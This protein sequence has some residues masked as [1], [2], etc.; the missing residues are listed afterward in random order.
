MQHCCTLQTLTVMAEVD[1]PAPDPSTETEVDEEVTE[2]NGEVTTAVT[3]LASCIVPCKESESVSAVEENPAISLSELEQVLPVLPPKLSQVPP[4]PPLSRSK[5]TCSQS[6]SATPPRPPAMQPKLVH[7]AQSSVAPGLPPVPPRRALHTMATIHSNPSTLSS[8]Q[9]PAATPSM[10]V[11]HPHPSVF[12]RTS[13]DAGAL[14]GTFNYV[15]FTEDAVPPPTQLVAKSRKLPKYPP[16]V[17]VFGGR[18]ADIGKKLADCGLGTPSYSSSD[19]YETNPAGSYVRLAVS[20]PHP[21]DDLLTLH[22]YC[23]PSI[24]AVVP[25]PTASACRIEPQ[26]SPPPLPM[27][28][29]RVGWWDCRW[30][31]PRG[32]S[33]QL[34]AVWSQRSTT[35]GT[36]SSVVASHMSLNNSQSSS[37]NTR[38]PPAAWR[39]RL[40]C[41]VRTCMHPCRWRRRRR[42]LRRAGLARC[43]EPSTGHL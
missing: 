24:D 26:H 2:V 32:H 43:R 10:V 11:P 21:A 6:F 34:R 18:R 41:F 42:Q 39:S 15:Y 8:L 36:E 20:S 25:A 16:D 40:L 30:R 17:N 4:R 33:S 28:S 13:P 14:G 19:G 1:T 38:R 3:N 35:Y 29:R 27:K 31:R 37:L 12:S 9:Q 23:Y 22:D 7:R 5:P